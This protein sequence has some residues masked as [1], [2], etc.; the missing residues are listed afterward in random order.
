MKMG[1]TLGIALLTLLAWTAIAS[2]QTPFAP[3]KWTKV[4]AAPP[5]VIG[6]TLLLTDGS[7]LAINA[8]CSATGNWYR[9]VPDSTGSYLKGSWV[10]AGTL[11]A[12]Y[13][14]LY[15]ASAV[16]PSG[17]VIIMG[18]EYNACKADW[19]TKGAIYNFN[20]NHWSNVAAPAG[21]TSV[22]DAQSVVLP[23]GKFMLANCCTED[24]AIATVTGL[25]VTWAPTGAGKFDIN[26]EEGWTL[27]PNGKVLAVDAYVGSYDPSGTNSESYNPAIGKWSSAG[28]TVVQLWD[29]AAACPPTGASQEVGPAVLRPDGTVFATGA[30]ACGA[31]NTSIFDTKTGIWS[32]GPV[33]PGALDVADGP[34]ALLRNG[35]VL[36]DASPL[37]FKNGSKFFEWDGTT[38]N[39]TAAPPGAALNPSYAGNML[40]LPTGQILFTDFSS[41]VSVYTPVG[42]ACA[43]C[44]PSITSVAA[45]LTH[46]SLNNAIHGKQ[47]NG[48]SQGAA[49]GDDAQSA[50]NYPL[51]RI[52]D[53]SGHVV[54][55]KTH[56]FSTMGVA[57]GSQIVSALFDIPASIALGP[58]KLVVVTNGIPSPAKV[59]TI[60]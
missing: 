6:H 38:L 43:G 33:F 7:V 59:V 22:G 12:G 56:G 47:F 58:A 44:A 5:S 30:N 40:V 51:V 24:Q 34:A 54:Y 60:N 31:G 14:P 3:G 27:L 28:S 23:N 20:S 19:T 48:L 37:I 52:T 25:S 55:C 50:T 35:N 36:V 39:P 49:Y 57:T 29:S 10:N 2:A 45:T 53:A 13:N 11:P 8:G 21:W 4:A 1:Q 32:A 9:L 26:D 18:G 15:F 41:T 46:G 42:T 17:N 16:L